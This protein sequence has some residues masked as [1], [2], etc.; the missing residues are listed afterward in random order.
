MVRQA[1]AA[2]VVPRGGAGRREAARRR[3]ARQRLARA[4][5]AR[6]QRLQALPARRPRLP[7]R[8]APAQGVRGGGHLHLR[9]P[10]VLNRHTILVLCS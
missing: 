7:P 3:L 5:L 10:S 1:G 4:R 8:A 6:A 9:R 2:L